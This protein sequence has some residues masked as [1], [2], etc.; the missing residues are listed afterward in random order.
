MKKLLLSLFVFFVFLLQAISQQKIITGKVTNSEDQ[1]P[2]I[3]AT[4]TV[5]GEK[6]GVVTDVHGIYSISAREGDTLKFSR[7]DIKSTEVAVGKSDLCN[8]ELG[9]E[10]RYKVA[11]GYGT[12]IRSEI[13]SSIT[14][15]DGES[16]KDIPVPTI[17][18]ALQGKSA[19][20]FIES[21]NGKVSGT[22]IMR[23]RGLSSI[24]ADQQPLFVVDGIPITTTAL[25]KLGAPINPLNSINLNDIESVEIL[26]DAASSAIYGSRGSNGVI[27]ITT[28]KG[29]N[30]NSKLDFTIRRGFN[31]ASHKR[32]FMKLV[33]IYFILPG[34]SRQRR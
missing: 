3:G 1:L 13:T 19:G 17:E 14:K 9:Y 32:E 34:G 2:V 21:V 28:R 11:V 31:E 24:N 12:R 7:N 16:L 30:G 33:R 26:K 18:Q 20:V 15:V 29:I 6:S 25:N 5:K 22:A 23:I 27:L 4:V 10:Q 8:V